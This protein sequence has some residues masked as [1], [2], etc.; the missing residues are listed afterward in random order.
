MGP[1]HTLETK[2]TMDDSK[3]PTIS[4]LIPC[5]NEEKTIERCVRS[6]LEQTRPADQIIVIDD[7][8][9]DN[10]AK[11]L[12]SFGS[13]IALIKLA[14]NTGNKSYVQQMGLS[15]VRGEI[16]ISTDAD[17]I[18]ES[19][20]LQHIEK[21]FSDP[22]VVAVAGYVKSTK[23][24][25]L[26]AVRELDYLIG[27]EVHKTAQSHINFLV[28][29]PGCAGAFRTQ[30]F[31]DHI[32]FDHDTLT[33]DLDFTYKINEQNYRLVFDKEAIVYTQDPADLHSYINQM[34]RWYGGGWQNLLK[35]LAI[36]NR[37]ASALELSLIYFEGL[38]FSTLMFVIPLVNI[39]FFFYFLLLY[40]LI[41][42]P[43]GIWGAISRKRADLVFFSPMYPIITYLNAY[44]FLEQF[45]SVILMRRK[46]FVWFSPARR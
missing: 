3:T 38:V 35:H 44:I 19:H 4:I 16:F 34:R 15:F 42:L 18:L 29:I 26:T 11:I 27:Q 17:T 41:I 12:E 45:A 10:S 32:L 24:N 46:N 25:W 2:N 6:C 36:A 40:S 39:L 23:F 5:H 13:L 43:F 1:V 20:F 7:G 14:K 22:K 37:P 33:E 31:R 21:D 30:V 28:V 8:S 9:T